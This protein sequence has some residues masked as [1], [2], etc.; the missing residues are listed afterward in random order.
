MEY[1]QLTLQDIETVKPF[2]NMMKSRTCDFTVGGMFMWR[3]FY[4]MEYAIEN[5]TF[6]SRLRD[7]NGRV[8]NNI[9][10]SADIHAAISQIIAHEEK[11]VRFCT[12]P[13]EYL[14]EF[15]D[16]GTA[17]ISEQE[18]FWDYLY[19][20][21]DLVLLKGK[22]Y[23]G[24][25]NLIRQFERNVDTWSF[26]IIDS[27][28]VNKVKSF[29]CETYLPTQKNGCFEQEENKKVLE[30]LENFDTYGMVGGYL[31]ADGKIVGFSI[32]EIVGDTLFT[33]VEKADRR[34]KGAYQMLVNQAALAFVTDTVCFINREED[35]GDL[36]LRTSKESY[37]PIGLLKKYTVEV[38]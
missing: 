23:N 2:Y 13:E 28:S 17:V 31:V 14:S 1:K 19:R 21:P 11:P 34:C 20:A 16:Y 9:P 24:Q 6:F 35:L 5:G 27:S 22:K 18:N 10:V 32:N 12:V 4:K 36:G 37:H 8:Y 38:G 30:V 26:E 15:S 25:R 33:H 7:Q 3:D 29:F